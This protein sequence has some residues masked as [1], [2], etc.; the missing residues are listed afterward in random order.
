MELGPKKY[1]AVKKVQDK[2]KREL[3]LKKAKKRLKSE[4]QSANDGIM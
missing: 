2:E 4:R 1:G 3:L